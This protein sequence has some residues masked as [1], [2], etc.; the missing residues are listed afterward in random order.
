M[1]KLRSAL[2]LLAALAAAALTARLGVWQLDRAAQKTALQQALQQQQ[3]LPPLAQAELAHSP[4]EL[5]PQLHR[6]VQLQ[7]RWLPAQ[8]V[9]LE[10]RQMNGRPGFYVVTPLLL[11]DGGAVLVQRG[12]VP[13]DLLDRTR[14]VA[15]P[16]PEGPVQV[17]G[18]IAPGPA[19][20]Y[21]FDGAASGAI[22]Q[23]LDP[24]LYARET[25]LALRPLAVVQEDGEAAHA[26]GL[27]RSWPQPAVDVH[28]HHGYAFQ[29]FALCALIIGLYV[30]FQLIRPA[31][32]R[33]RRGPGA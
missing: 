30:W 32:Q 22:R 10:N 7:G 5:P 9:Y 17:L 8:T 6:R 23:N 14:V 33:A 11:A 2:V 31:R 1:L 21:E 28:K 12:W 27:L 16:P 19:R 18:R 13:R 4:A 20:L 24:V 25:G 26:D 3:A 29:W 15:P